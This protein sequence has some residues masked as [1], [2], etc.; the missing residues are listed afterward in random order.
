M[1]T[2]IK[3]LSLMAC[4]AGTLTFAAPATAQ[5]VQQ[6]TITFRQGTL[7]EVAFFKIKA[8]KEKSL[9]RDY[10][11]KVVPLAKRY[12]ASVLGMF[13]VARIDH[14]PD[15]A[16]AWGFFEWPSL[17]AKQRFDADPTFR[18][19]RP[20]RDR[21]LDSLKVTY[22]RVQ[23][24]TTVTIRSDKYYEVYGG[25]INKGNAAHLKEYFAVCGPAI[26]KLGARFPV[27][28]EV[29]GTPKAYAFQPDVLGFVEWPSKSAKEAWYA[30]PEFRQVGWHRAL[31]VDR[32][33]V[34]EGHYR[35]APKAQPAN[36]SSDVANSSSDDSCGA[37]TQQ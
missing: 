6:S 21:L 7:V 18:R 2:H 5:D 13:D 34:V 11:S 28:F 4:L 1:S 30:S 26:A 37:C 23:A 33:Y 22:L 19:L 31:A 17:E 12:G 16:A 15:D 32:L 29:I 25:W 8:G 24:T 10:F 3:A 36:A 35:F 9:N 20:I 27:Q 14:G